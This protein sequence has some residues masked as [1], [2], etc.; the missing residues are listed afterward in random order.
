MQEHSDKTQK[1]RISIP[2][3]KDDIIVLTY[4]S[5]RLC[6][7]G[8]GGFPHHGHSGQSRCRQKPRVRGTPRLP[9]PPQWGA[10]ADPAVAV[11]KGSA[12]CSTSNPESVPDRANTHTH[13]LPITLAEHA[14]KQNHLFC[15]FCKGKGQGKTKEHSRH[16]CWLRQAR[17]PHLCTSGRCEQLQSPFFFPVSP[18]EGWTPLYQ[19]FPV[20]C[21]CSRRAAGGR[22]AV[23]PAVSPAQPEALPAAAPAAHGPISPQD[24]PLASRA[25]PLLPQS[26]SI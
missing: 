26:P 8:L 16:M 13:S 2:I 1:A 12:G 25:T 10:A 4:N 19:Q 24:V 20:K 5:H 7:A 23:S 9:S 6:R 14:E 15:P 11:G 21:L 22:R 17:N 18:A 3:K